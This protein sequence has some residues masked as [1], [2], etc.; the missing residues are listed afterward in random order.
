MAFR[1]PGPHMAAAAHGRGN[2]E[3]HDSTLMNHRG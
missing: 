2:Q 3:P 1:A